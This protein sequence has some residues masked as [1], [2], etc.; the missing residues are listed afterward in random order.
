ML[1]LQLRWLGKCSSWCSCKW[2]TLVQ[3]S[4]NSM[5]FV[6]S[7][8]HVYR[9]VAKKTAE[10]SNSDDCRLCGYFQGRYHWRCTV[11]LALGFGFRKWGRLVSNKCVHNTWP[12]EERDPETQSD[13][14]NATG[15]LRQVMA[16]LWKMNPI[17]EIYRNIK[18]TNSN[19]FPCVVSWNV[20]AICPKHSYC[21]K[22]WE[23]TAEIALRKKGSEDRTEQRCFWSPV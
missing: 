11:S 5:R 20:N 1:Q 19:C 12:L 23:T 9:V 13:M 2:Q 17:L 18:T 21:P 22:T 3:K 10:F 4:S 16:K 7:V 6:N 15:N 8:R 14:G